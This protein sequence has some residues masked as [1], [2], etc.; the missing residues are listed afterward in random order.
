DAESRLEQARS[1]W[2]AAQASVAWHEAHLDQL[3]ADVTLAK[4]RVDLADAR[5]ELAKAKAVSKL[6]RPA[7]YDVPVR[8]FEATVEDHETRL[9]MAEVDVD[10]WKKKVDLR[11]KALDARDDKV[12][13]AG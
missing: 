9:K 1:R 11:Q 7:I 8:D 12:K 2:H 3:K 13:D 10:G 5:V 6:D 4:L